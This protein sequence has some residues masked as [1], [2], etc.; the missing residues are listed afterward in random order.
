MQLV[1]ELSPTGEFGDVLPGQI[2]DLAVHKGYAYLNSWDSPV[3]ERGGTYV[4]DIRNPANPLEVGF[5]P[6]LPDYHHGE[7]A[8]VVTLDTPQFQGDV[9][10]VS[11][12]TYGFNV[13]APCAPTDKTHGGFDL[14]DVSDPLSP[15]PLVQGSGDQSPDDGTVTPVPAEGAPNS[16]DSVFVWQNGTQAFLAGVDNLELHDL[17]IYD[18]TDPASP[19]FIAEYDLFTKFPQVRGTSARGNATFLSDVVVKRIGARQVMSAGYGDAGYVQLD[20]TDPLD[21]AFVSDTFES[22][23]P[24]PGFD[25]PGGNAHQSEFSGDSQLLLAA[26]LDVFPSRLLSEI[27]EAP[28]EG[29]DFAA[30]VS[31]AEPLPEEGLSGATV[32]VGAACTVSP[33]PAG[34]TI[35]V[36]ERGGACP[37]FQEKVD[38]IEDAGYDGA[39]VMNNDFGA[40]GGRCEDLRLMD[41]DPATV[42]IPSLFVGRADGLRIL[43]AFDPNDYQCTGAEDPTPGDTQAP[44]VDSIGGLT[45][46]VELVHD[47][48]GYAHLYDAVTGEE[49]DAFVIPESLDEAFAE[50][51]GV[52]SIREVA[53][54]PTDNLAYSSY[55]AGGVRVFS[56]GRQDGLVQVGAYIDPDGSNFW[57]VEQFTTPDGRRL[58]AASDRDFGL[59][60]FRYTG[61]AAGPAN[62]PGS[63]GDAPVP[64]A[65]PSNRFTLRLGKFGRGRL[66]VTVNVPGAGRL[67]VR[68]SL[69]VKPA[70]GAAGSGRAH[71]AKFVRLARVT[72]RPTRS[73]RVRVVLRLS[74][75]KRRQL[76]KVLR[77]APRG[78]ARGRVNIAFTPTG[79]TTRKS[80]RR[81]TLRP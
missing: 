11:N 23:D 79:G 62:P 39:I 70:R 74:K 53:T 72:R 34:V 51:F 24:Q 61:P 21:P 56:F 28:H 54:D 50:G 6:A 19:E 47:G 30:V 46:N 4:M 42:N 49:L 27:T 77:K 63:V 52:L 44:P 9:L 71:V 7:G 76:A 18:I 3:C 75:A 41:L 59:Q 65:A 36:A 10:A 68:A 66:V 45:V 60:I 22:P 38:E 81:I 33:P 67:D 20:V 25:S 80:A 2:A 78:R 55:G 32:F 17:D 14:Y 48:W 43:N 26:D 64:P 37:T 1:G 8:Q 15:Q 5:I 57:G 58:I 69:F 12:E 35:A 29:L 13:A 31:N 40:D 16:Y 73:G